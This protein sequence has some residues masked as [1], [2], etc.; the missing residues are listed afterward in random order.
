[1]ETKGQ[2]RCLFSQDHPSIH[3]IRSFCLLFRYSS[4]VP[5]AA[6]WLYSRWLL[7]SISTK[8]SHIYRP[9]GLLDAL[10]GPS[11]ESTIARLGNCR[12]LLIHY[13]ASTGENS[14]TRL[15]HKMFLLGIT[16]SVLALVGT[17]VSHTVQ[18]QPHH[19]FTN[20]TRISRRVG[21]GS[22]CGPDAGACDEG[23]CCSPGVRTPFPVFWPGEILTFMDRVSAELGENTA[24]HR[25]V[26][27]VM[28]LR[29]MRTFSQ[30]EPTL[31][32]LLGLISATCHT[33]SISGPAQLPEPWP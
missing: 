19:S 32:K 4:T 29:A 5:L 10:L 6:S 27:S 2:S 23:L 28:A 11:A 15:H 18:A 16:G 12:S 7:H 31:R 17:A 3:H 1:M 9:S 33:E 14:S 13:R 8:I 21:T 22:P 24:Q 26:S 20:A 25:G 30:R